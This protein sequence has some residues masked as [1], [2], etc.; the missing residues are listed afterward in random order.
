[1]NDNTRESNCTTFAHDAATSIT[2]PSDTCKFCGRRDRDRRNNP[3]PATYR[4]Y[5]TPYPCLRSTERSEYEYHE[6]LPIGRS[7]VNTPSC[8]TTIRSTGTTSPAPDMPT[9]SPVKPSGTSRPIH[10]IESVSGIIKS[11]PKQPT[12][13][14]STKKD[15][16]K[17]T[18]Q[19]ESSIDSR[20]SNGDDYKF[21]FSTSKIIPQI[22]QNRLLGN[23]EGSKEYDLV[24]KSGTVN[25]CL[26]KGQLVLA[27]YIN[28]PAS[29]LR[30]MWY[31]RP[32]SPSNLHIAYCRDCRTLVWFNNI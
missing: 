10:R 14:L 13:E 7:D 21:D 5:P 22:R 9:D 18:Q 20:K 19:V 15:S 2:K 6:L 11:S 26:D 16:P 24:G 1:M 3:L 4:P 17:P 32:I 27:P 8:T 31:N 23:I 25:N 28:V 30:R 29:V 12:D